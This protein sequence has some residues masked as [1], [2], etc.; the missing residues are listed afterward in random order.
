ME[1]NFIFATSITLIFF[2]YALI[3]FFSLNHSQLKINEAN[4]VLKDNAN[5]ANESSALSSITNTQGLAFIQKRAF[6]FRKN[7]NKK[8]LIPQSKP[9]GIGWA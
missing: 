6:F 3:Q 5:I 2:V 8:K 4:R 7:K 9:T 1:A